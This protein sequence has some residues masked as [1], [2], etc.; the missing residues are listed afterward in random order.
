MDEIRRLPCGF[1]MCAADRSNR[2]SVGAGPKLRKVILDVILVLE[3]IISC[4]VIKG[5]DIGVEENFRDPA[6]FSIWPCPRVIIS[7]TLRCLI[8]A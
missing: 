2:S 3:L 5:A 4:V 6:V 7:E 1:A 8:L